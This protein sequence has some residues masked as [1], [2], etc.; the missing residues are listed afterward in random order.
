MRSSKVYLLILISLLAVFGI[1][2]GA[3][4]VYA[5]AATVGSTGGIYAALERAVQADNQALRN[6]LDAVLLPQKRLWAVLGI[7]GLVSTVLALLAL[8]IGWS[9]TK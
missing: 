9:S 3:A 2:V 6:E 7:G 4:S 1:A 8:V 5:D